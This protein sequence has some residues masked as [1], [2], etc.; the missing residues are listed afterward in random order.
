MI[1]ISNGEITILFRVLI[2][3]GLLQS[4]CGG[5]GPARKD[6]GSICWRKKRF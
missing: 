1:V 2:S 5:A 4:F 6:D 3:V